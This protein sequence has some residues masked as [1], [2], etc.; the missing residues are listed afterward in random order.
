MTLSQKVVNKLNL[1]TL[2]IIASIVV[3]IEVDWKVEAW[4][5]FLLPHP[6]WVQ[7]QQPRKRGSFR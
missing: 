1:L 5:G 6:S 2:T 7:M 4:L 3:T